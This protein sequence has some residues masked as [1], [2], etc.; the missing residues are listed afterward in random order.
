MASINKVE[1]LSEDKFQYFK[2]ICSIYKAIENGEDTDEIK[3]K[4]TDLFGK[5]EEFRQ[6]L[7]SVAAIDRKIDDLNAELDSSNHMMKERRKVLKEALEVFRSF[8]TEL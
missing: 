5:F 1:M 7:K 4:V 8:T 3:K 6:K 2:D